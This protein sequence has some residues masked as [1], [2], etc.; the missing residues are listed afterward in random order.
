MRETLGDLEGFER[1]SRVP[2][3]RRQSVK[4][5]EV[6]KEDESREKNQAKMLD[7][8]PVLNLRTIGT[9]ELLRSDSE[10]TA[11]VPPPRPSKKPHSTLLKPHPEGNAEMPSASIETEMKH[12]ISD[13][14]QATSG[15]LTDT[16]FLVKDAPAARKIPYR[17]LN[18]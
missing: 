15:V 8:H 12:L 7:I 17:L 13:Y 14:Q 16:K 5:V 11:A 3:S 6:R 18:L 2:Y 9:I 10:E 4:P 1:A